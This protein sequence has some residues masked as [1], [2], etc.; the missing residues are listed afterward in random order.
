MYVQGFT[1][2]NIPFLR[3]SPRGGWHSLNKNS[4]KIVTSGLHASIPRLFRDYFE[5]MSRL[6]TYKLL[7]IHEDNFIFYLK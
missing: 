7:L 1:E 4:R 2:T 5:S 6:F 3:H